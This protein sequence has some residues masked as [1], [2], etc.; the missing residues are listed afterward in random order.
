MNPE[1]KLEQYFRHQVRLLGGRCDKL[2]PSTAGMPDRLIVLP[3]GRIFLVEL[4]TKTG[5]L[6][7]AQR[8]YH[9][10]MWELG[11]EVVVLYGREEVDSWLRSVR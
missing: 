1:T 7:P 11:V 10:Q 3:R 9:Q 6:R 4:K 5:A 2:I 8:L